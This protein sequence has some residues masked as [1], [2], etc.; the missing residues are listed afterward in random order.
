MSG[1]IDTATGLRFGTGLNWLSGGLGGDGLD[2]IAVP[3]WVLAAGGVTASLD[4]DFVNN[5]AYNS[6][7][8]P[9]TPTIASLLTC[10]RATPAAAYY[11]K[12]DGTLMSFAPNVIRYGTNGL[13][14][15]EARTNLALRSQEF[16]NAYWTKTNITVTPDAVNAPDGTLTADAY[17]PNAGIVGVDIRRAAITVVNGSAYTLSIYAKIGTLVGFPWHELTATDGVTTWRAWFNLSTGAKGT[18]AGSP[19]SYNIT[20]LAN[21]WYRLDMTMTMGAVGLGI[22]F[23]TRNGDGTSGT[24]TGDGTS[25]SCYIWGAQL[26]LGAFATSY[27]PTTTVSVTRAAD[28]VQVTSFGTFPYAVTG[29]LYANATLLFV[30]AAS[31]DAWQFDDNST[32]NFIALNANN[33]A[34]SMNFNINSGAATQCLITTSATLTAGVPIKLAGAYAANDFMASATGLLGTPDVSGTIPTVTQ[35]T[36]GSRHNSTNILNGYLSRIAYWNSRI[37]NANLQVLTT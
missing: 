16:D 31:Q 15:E 26:E 32:S 35:V 1:L 6:S 5:L 27:I 17:I 13:L 8:N 4:V 37:S 14:V 20:A 28:K 3:T 36:I 21:G 22:F 19:T 18:S 24:I 10:T 12:A 7:G 34:G 25:P 29:T 2:I 30:S 33:A 9:T 23:S 11:T